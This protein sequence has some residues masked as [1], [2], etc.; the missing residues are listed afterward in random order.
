MLG[1]KTLLLFAT[2][3]GCALVAYALTS[4]FY[5]QAKRFP[6]WMRHGKWRVFTAAL[7]MGGILGWFLSHAFLRPAFGWCG[8]IFVPLLLRLFARLCQSQTARRLEESSLPFFHALLGF[9]RAGLGI[10]TAILRAMEAAPGPFTDWMKDRLA[11]RERGESV[12]EALLRIHRALPDG[13]AARTL[14]IL[15]RLHAE[16]LGV[17]NLLE[18][19]VGWMAR[20]L[21]RHRKTHS[22]QASLILQGVLA[23]ALPWAVLFLS[24]PAGAESL[25]TFSTEQLW[26]AS[27]WI[28]GIAFSAAWQI[29]GILY[30]A[31]LGRF[32]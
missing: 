14:Q 31:R 16:G 21:A 30:L 6:A 25:G 11:R 2:A 18:T 9:L 23:S 32:F 12:G 13:D 27:D 4:D 5:H 15:A 22:L 8:L 7:A 10:P 24:G 1:E 29:V 17:L 28:G 20:E 19:Q 26:S 3:A